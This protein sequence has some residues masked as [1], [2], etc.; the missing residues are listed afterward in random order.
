MVH[1]LLHQRHSRSRFHTR[2]ISTVS[3]KTSHYYQLAVV[4]S[5]IVECRVVQL[6]YVLRS[7]RVDR[8]LLLL[9]RLSEGKQQNCAVFRRHERRFRG[10]GWSVCLLYTSDAADE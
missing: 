3:P 7:L 8:Q 10:D 6:M 4:D 1:T 9:Y 2:K 5:S